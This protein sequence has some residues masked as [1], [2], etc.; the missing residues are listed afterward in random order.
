MENRMLLIPHLSL[1]N[2]T[3]NFQNKLFDISFG[4]AIKKI[5]PRYMFKSNSL[6]GC[7]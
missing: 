2:K 4:D 5:R 7:K 3:T 1:S 6:P